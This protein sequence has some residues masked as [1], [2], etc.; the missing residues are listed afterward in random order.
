MGAFHF[1]CELAGDDL[2]PASTHLEDSTFIRD[3]ARGGH[4]SSS[5]RGAR[6]QARTAASQNSASVRPAITVFSAP[7]DP[8]RTA[9][10]AASASNAKPSN[11]GNRASPPA[12]RSDTQ[13]G[14]VPFTDPGRPPVDLRDREADMRAVHGAW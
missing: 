4:A 2:E 6:P 11:S 13:Q 1:S 12:R 10:S 7:K 5:G 9:A 14:L 3:E 8:V